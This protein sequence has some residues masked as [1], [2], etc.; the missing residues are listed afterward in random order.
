MASRGRG[1]PRAIR[2]LQL[3]RSYLIGSE[4]PDPDADVAPE[5]SRPLFRIDP[6]DGDCVGRMHRSI[7]LFIRASKPRYQYPHRHS[8]NTL[9]DHLVTLQL[10][11]KT[12]RR[13]P[14][15]LRGASS[16]RGT[17]EGQA[18]EVS[19]STRSGGARSGRDTGLPLVRRRTPWGITSG[20]R[21]LAE[22]VP[23]INRGRERWRPRHG[24][25]LTGLGA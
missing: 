11:E 2:L 19:A 7:K 13:E 9:I 20:A 16:A 24:V 18:L 22:L 10:L 1:A 8:F 15:Q 3:V 12:Y 23:I 14:P 25:M 4:F 6:E 5:E 17:G 21:D